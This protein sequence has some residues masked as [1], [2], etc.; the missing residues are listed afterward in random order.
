MVEYDES[1]L[2]RVF[3]ALADPTRRALLERL[4]VGERK[5]GELAAPFPI[6]L[7]A[8]SKHVRVLEQAGLVERR[9]EGRTHYCRLRPEPLAEAE[10]WLSFYEGFWSQRLNALEA[11][12]KA[13]PGGESTKGERQ[14]G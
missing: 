14:D 11:A 2:D 10:Q 12:L 4:A 7:A 3:H 13:D 6:S 1:H 8:V 9:I 5:I